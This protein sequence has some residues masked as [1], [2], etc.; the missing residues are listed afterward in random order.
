MTYAATTRSI[1]L[2][3]VGALVRVGGHRESFCVWSWGLL[4]VDYEKEIVGRGM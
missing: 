4:M 2:D 3:V 1:R